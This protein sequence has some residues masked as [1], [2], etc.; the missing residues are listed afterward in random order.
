MSVEPS[1]KEDLIE[2]LREDFHISWDEASDVL[3]IV[4]LNLRDLVIAMSDAGENRQWSL[5]LRLNKKLEALAVNLRW[6]TLQRFCLFL[7]QAAE[8]ENEDRTDLLL[9][10]LPRLAKPLLGKT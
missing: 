4:R 10:R 1:Q 3:R 9:T 7:R 6:M 8:T 2:K 5:L